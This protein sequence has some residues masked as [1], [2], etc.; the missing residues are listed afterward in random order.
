MNSPVIAFV[1]MTHL[2]LNSAVASANRGFEVLCFDPDP[3]VVAALDSGKPM[4]VEPDLP[5][6]MA[7]NR[8]HITY[9]SDP[10]DLVLA[11][12]IYIAPDVPTDDR[13]ESDLGS[14]MR[15]VETVD[16]AARP[17]A[18][19]VIL[20]Q[21]PP[22][23]TR[24]LARPEAT[25]FYQVETLVFGRAIDR[26][27]NPERF[28][29]GAADPAQPLPAPLSAYLAAFDC[30]ILPMRYESAELSKIAINMCLV[31]SVTTANVLAELCEGI[32]ADWSEIAPALKLDRRIGPHAYL[33]AGLGIAGGNLERD[34][35]TLIRI[36]ARHGTDVAMMQ[37]W[38]ANSTHR[39]YWALHQLHRTVL[40]TSSAPVI[41]VLGLA[42]KENTHSVKN[43]P[44]VALIEGLTPYA[45]QAYDPVVKADSAWHPRLRQMPT[46]IAA[47]EGVD[48]LVLMTPWPEFREIDPAELAGRMSGRTVFDP[49]GLLDAA[50]CMTAGLAH[51]RLG[52]SVADAP[53]T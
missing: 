15:F 17:D 34:I 10:R 9:T 32:D 7:R 30:P 21:V 33:A 47:A 37:A 25:R 14:L 50:G 48:A 18:I 44:A 4:V 38:R 2:G 39:R 45:I 41:G 52:K 53:R 5:E 24:S 43:S 46:A 51:L 29:I 40:R 6:M 22:G 27:H 12:V 23:F 1:G 11:D 35:A 31:A 3:S 20:S 8:D 19:V 49:F 36:G 42:Y 16:R 26:A 28:I 13:G